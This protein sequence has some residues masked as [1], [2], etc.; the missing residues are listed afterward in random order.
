MSCS[1]ALSGAGR[2]VRSAPA[3]RRCVPE[4]VGEATVTLLDR[5]RGH[6]ERDRSCVSPECLA[7]GW[8]N[9]L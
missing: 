3:E 4:E 1:T 5:V 7:T 9:G 2:V 8:V 6:L